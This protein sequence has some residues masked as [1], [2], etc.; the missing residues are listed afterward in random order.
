MDTTALDA[1][2]AEYTQEVTDT[3]GLDASVEALIAAQ[4]EA[5]AKAV[6]DAVAAATAQQGAADQSVVDTAVA[7]VRDT[8]ARFKAASTTLAAAINT[9][10]APTV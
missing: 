10:P 3:E 5:T 9:P 4:G 1:A 8:T 6:A 7:A 2:I